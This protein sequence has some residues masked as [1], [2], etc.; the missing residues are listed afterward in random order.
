[1]PRT[2]RAIT[3]WCNKNARGIIRLACCYS[4]S[5]RKYYLSPQSIEEVIKEERKKVQYVEYKEGSLLSADAEDLS[6]QVRN[7]RGEELERET[8]ADR[9]RVVDEGATP[10]HPV[11]PASRTGETGRTAQHSKAAGA[12]DAMTEDE[13]ASLKELQM[14]N[15]DLRVQLEGQKYLVR[16]YDELVAGERERHEG[17]K[18]ALVDRLTDA[19]HQIGS[20]EEK[21]LRL[22]APQASVR[23]AETADNA[24]MSNPARA[25]QQELD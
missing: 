6:E 14:E 8:H 4:E 15:F 5:E 1:M 19:R 20:L 10:E 7:E 18:L 16:K 22:D 13:Q 3:N 17:E 24:G 25:Y 11:E 23:D 9:S 2:E 21:L 12:T